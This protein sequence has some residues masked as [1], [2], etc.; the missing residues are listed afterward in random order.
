MK[1]KM[2]LKINKEKKMD[3]KFITY[4]EIKKFIYY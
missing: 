1:A 2:K 3:L 4:F